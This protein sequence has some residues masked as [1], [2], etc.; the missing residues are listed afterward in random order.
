MRSPRLL[1]A[2]RLGRRPDLDLQQRCREPG[3]LV[4]KTRIDAG[5]RSLPPAETARLR[6]R[7]RAL[8]SFLVACSLADGSAC[9]SVLQDTLN[10]NKPVVVRAT[11]NQTVLTRTLYASFPTA[12]AVAAQYTHAMTAGEPRTTAL[13]SIDSVAAC[14]V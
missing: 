4:R 10:G 11:F 1:A 6:E 9:F 3:R 12:D 5:S 8:L 7:V 13:F 2:S 14:L